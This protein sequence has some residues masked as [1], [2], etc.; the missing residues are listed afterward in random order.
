MNYIKAFQYMLYYVVVYEHL[1]LS[2]NSNELQ[3]Q[4]KYK[5]MAG[6]EPNMAHTVL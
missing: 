3:L 5:S 2:L 1:S 4:S 6:S